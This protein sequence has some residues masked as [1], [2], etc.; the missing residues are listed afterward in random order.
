MIRLCTNLVKPLQVETFSVLLSVG[1][2][3]QFQNPVHTQEGALQ[4]VQCDLWTLSYHN[5]VPVLSSAKPGF[6]HLQAE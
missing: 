1:L 3:T 4:A 5:N 6:G 2:C